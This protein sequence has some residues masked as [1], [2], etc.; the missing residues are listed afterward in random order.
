MGKVLT[1]ALLILI[2]IM[3]IG[4]IIK[5][6]G[7]YGAATGDYAT[8]PFVKGFLDGY[9]TMDTIAALNFGMHCSSYKI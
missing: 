9:L 5:P 4:S 2:L 6:I 1:P 3:V 7:G 8:S